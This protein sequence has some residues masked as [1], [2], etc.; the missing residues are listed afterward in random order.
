M[1]T[2]GIAAGARPVMGA[3]IESVNENNLENVAIIATGCLGYC[4]A[5]PLVTVTVPD[6]GQ[7]YYANVDEPL[8][9]KIIERHV[10]NGEIIGE[11]VLDAEG[12]S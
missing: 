6:G 5:E 10:M 4:Y 12:P 8:A 7:T 9:R 1:A 11:S 2:C 3:L